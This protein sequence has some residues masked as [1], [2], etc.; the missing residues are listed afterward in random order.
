MDAAQTR[1]DCKNKKN[2]RK[3]SE[4]DQEGCTVP[5]PQKGK[6]IMQNVI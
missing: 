4:I 1:K 3:W 2:T 6:S 5:Y